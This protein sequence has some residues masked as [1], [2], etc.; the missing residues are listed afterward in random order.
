MRIH[1]PVDRDT[2]SDDIVAAP[3]GA[4]FVPGLTAAGLLKFRQGLS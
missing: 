3:E 2:C 4:A 1:T